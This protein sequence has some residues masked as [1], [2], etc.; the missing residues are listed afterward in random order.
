[1]LFGTGEGA[2]DRDAADGSLA[3]APLPK[4][5]L[6]IS[7]E[8]GGREAR[9]LYAGPAPGSVY[10]LLQINAVVPAGLAPGKASAVVTAGGVRSAPGVT[11]AV[12]P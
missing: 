6:P 10:G 12:Q 11:I 3:A 5:K 4:P 1:M 8:I 2:L 9:V 7:V